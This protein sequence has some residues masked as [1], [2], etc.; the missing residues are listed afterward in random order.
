MKIK[1]YGEVFSYL[2]ELGSIITGHYFHPGKFFEQANLDITP[3]TKIAEIGC[4]TARWALAAAKHCQKKGIATVVE[5]AD[6]SPHM[7]KI[8]ERKA[9]RKKVPLELYQADGRDL[10]KARAFYNGSI[11]CRKKRFEDESIDLLISSGMLE[12]VTENVE[13]AMEELTRILKPGGK[14]ILPLVNMNSAGNLASKVL[15]FRLVPKEY[16]FAKLPEIT[17]ESVPVQSL[18]RYMEAI[19]TI[20]VGTKN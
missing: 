7:L 14:I 4:G 10:T 19:Q 13:P 17:F 12:C 1:E 16:A 9:K 6:I 8:A 18:T 20:Y 15:R 2:Y 11:N 3:E 5:G